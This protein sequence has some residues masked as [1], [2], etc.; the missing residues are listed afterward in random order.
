M[1]G[2][3][4]T[5]NALEVRDHFGAVLERLEKHGQ[6]ILVS[7]G[8]RIRAVLIT[9]EDFQTRFVD[10]LAEDARDRMLRSIRGARSARLDGS[11]IDEALRDLRG[12]LA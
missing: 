4:H 8:R 10:R 12:D 5:V 3:I 1:R 2:H 9:P 6:P 7:K 11:E